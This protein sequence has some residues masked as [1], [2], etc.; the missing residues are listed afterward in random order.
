ML[1]PESESSRFEGPV[2][3][4]RDPVIEIISTVALAAV[5][6]GRSSRAFAALEFEYE[7][8]LQLPG[9]PRILLV[10]KLT[11]LPPDNL[12][13][14]RFSFGDDQASPL[15]GSN[16]PMLNRLDDAMVYT[17]QAEKAGEAGGARLAAELRAR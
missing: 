16:D 1:E 17:K 9:E 7:T 14:S 6:Q 8:W 2:L 12:T 5:F 15:G 11:I 4:P 13:I 3:D 10:P